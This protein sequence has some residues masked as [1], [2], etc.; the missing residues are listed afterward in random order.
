M[1]STNVLPSPQTSKQVARIAAVTL[2]GIAYFALIIVALHFLRPDLDP[3]SQPTSQYAA[4]PYGFLMTS[5]FLS[6]SLASFALAFGLARALPQPARSRSG[7]ALLGLWAVG[8]LIAM[9]FPLNEVGAAET[10][11]STIHR[12]AGPLTFISLTAGVMLVSWR[13]KHSDEWRPLYQPA[14]ILSLVIVAAFVATFLTLGLFP[15]SG[16]GGLSQRILLATVVTWFLLTAV[17]LRTL[18]QISQRSISV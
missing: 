13:F 10:V 18:H 5:A 12:A 14:L 15:E 11:S 9:I 6:L 3:I 4:G 8:V 17:R 7:L 1:T 2:V 16:I